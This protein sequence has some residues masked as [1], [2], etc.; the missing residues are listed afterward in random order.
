M[1][2]IALGLA[3]C[4]ATTLALSAPAENSSPIPA[5]DSSSST[6][7]STP[8]EDTSSAP[9]SAALLP[10]TTNTASQ[11][12]TSPTDP[13]VSAGLNATQALA[14]STFTC[15]NRQVGYYAD[16]ETDC[17]V[18]HFCL[19][20]QFNGEPMYQRVPYM[21]L[22]NTVFDQQVLDC[23]DASNMTA[24]CKESAKYYDESNVILRKAMIV[25][26]VTEE[27]KESDKKVDEKKD[28]E[29]TAA[30]ESEEKNET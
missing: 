26:P 29:E 30:T 23:V 16:I 2:I 15:L 28:E 3:I 20:G 19:L 9:I 14:N 7:S 27:I 8:A 4:L 6:S 12:E 13:G 24:P 22:N 17:K 11:N 21:C 5:D 18:Y 25:K 10:L 1:K